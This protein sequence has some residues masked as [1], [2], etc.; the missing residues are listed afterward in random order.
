MEPF[1]LGECSVA[2]VLHSRFKDHAHVINSD[3]A[4]IVFQQQLQHF[5]FHKFRECFG[6]H[7]NTQ[8]QRICNFPGRPSHG[9]IPA[10]Q[11][12]KWP[13]Y[14]SP[15]FNSQVT[16]WPMPLASYKTVTV[17]W[18]MSVRLKTPKFILQ[19]RCM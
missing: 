16:V 15:V 12:I 6:Y 3:A 19:Y 4:Q 8:T 11:F 14:I 18:E 5:G 7:E 10:S 9:V 17:G 1:F 2:I 13:L